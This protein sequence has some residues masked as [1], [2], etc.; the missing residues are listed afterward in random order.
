MGDQGGMEYFYELSG[1]ITN[2]LKEELGYQAR[3]RFLFDE[4]QSAFNSYK[5]SQ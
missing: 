1:P 3:R 4:M 2:L 5:L